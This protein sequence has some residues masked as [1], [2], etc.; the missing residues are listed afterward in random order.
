MTFENSDSEFN[1]EIMRKAALYCQN[2]EKMKVEK[3]GILLYGSCG[4]GK[5]YAAA[6]I[7][8]RLVELGVST[9]I[10]TLS[11]LVSDRVNALKNGRPPL[12]LREF[13]VV[14]L[15]DLGVE[16]V[17]KTAFEIV[18]DL[19]NMQCIVIATTNLS[20]KELRETDDL[21]RRR[22]FD[23]II[24]LTGCFWKVDSDSRRLS[25]A[26]RKSE[27]VAKIFG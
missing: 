22:L 23:R 10:T 3:I 13:Q 7:A 17:T 27:M 14:V 21:Q 5:T 19:Y 9:L 15:D 26:K 6:A 12:N 18:D 8:N 2:F 11:G 20:P 4:A 25:V 1:S 24:E 16:N